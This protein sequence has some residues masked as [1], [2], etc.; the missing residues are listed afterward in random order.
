MDNVLN[1]IEKH[2]QY[3]KGNKN[4]VICGKNFYTKYDSQIFYSS[5]SGMVCHEQCI[6]RRLF[7]LFTKDLFCSRWLHF[8]LHYICSDHSVDL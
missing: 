6:V 2:K 3:L 5:G 8:N 1:I 4:C 7:F